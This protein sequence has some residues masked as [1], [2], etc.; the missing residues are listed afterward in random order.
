MRLPL[1]IVGSLLDQWGD[2]EQFGNRYYYNDLIMCKE[3][4][5]TFVTSYQKKFSDRLTKEDVNFIVENL[6]FFIEPTNMT[7]D[8]K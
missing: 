8:T 5:I 7:N 1:V 3:C 2:T 4:F 6:H